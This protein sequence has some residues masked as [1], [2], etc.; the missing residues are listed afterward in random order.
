M[1]F[2]MHKASGRR[3]L[4]KKQFSTGISHG[5]WTLPYGANYGVYL[6]FYLHVALYIILFHRKTLFMW[7]NKL[8][9]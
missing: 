7:P 4:K 1:C 3:R 8:V 2:N 5:R 9:F 6:L